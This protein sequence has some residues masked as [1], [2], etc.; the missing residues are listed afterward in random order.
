M[1]QWKGL[2]KKGNGHQRPNRKTALGFAV[3]HVPGLEVIDEGT[4]RLQPFG[5]CHFAAYTHPRGAMIST[6]NSDDNEF[7]SAPWHERDHIMLF[8]DF[9]DGKRVAIYVCD[10]A[11]LFQ[12]RTIGHHGVRW[13]D[14]VALA[15]HR[16]IIPLT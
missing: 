7:G 14:V 5:T 3:A 9:G 13:P 16:Q 1:A 12:R 4:V 11:P 15:K 6:P 2:L 8:R 10:I